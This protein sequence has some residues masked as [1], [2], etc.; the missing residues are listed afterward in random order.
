MIL[1]RLIAPRLRILIP[2][3][4]CAGIFTLS[5]LPGGSKQQVDPGHTLL[6]HLPPLIQ[7]ILHIPLFGGL[8][9]SWYW[10]LQPWQGWSPRRRLVA[11]FLLTA[12]FAAFDEWYQS[13]VPD[14]TASLLDLALDL[15]GAALGSLLASRLDPR[16]VS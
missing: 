12:I 3:A 11:A 4:Y 14:R 2:A 13:F 9:W 6:A 10:A 8:A 7:N 1:S 5:S 16:T 15:V